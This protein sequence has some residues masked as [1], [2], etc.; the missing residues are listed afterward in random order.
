[1]C[2]T[3]F[4]KKEFNT[5][6]LLYYVRLQIL[7]SL[8][9]LPCDGS[10]CKKKRNETSQDKMIYTS[11]FTQYQK[12]CKKMFCIDNQLSLCIYQQKLIVVAYLL[13]LGT[14]AL[15]K[16]DVWLNLDN[17]FN[18]GLQNMSKTKNLNKATAKNKKQPQALYL[19]THTFTF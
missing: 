8:R 15:S 6:L 16:T 14:K 9:C 5:L 2:P 11:D 12:K 19:K 1:M 10:K 18:V 17:T 13:H 4:Y 7:F 3:H